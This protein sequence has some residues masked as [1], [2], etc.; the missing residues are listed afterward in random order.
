MLQDSDSMLRKYLLYRT[1]KIENEAGVGLPF[2]KQQE[3]NSHK[4]RIVPLR[5]WW[6]FRRV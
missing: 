6:I 3:K 1:G 5:D 2:D 4:W